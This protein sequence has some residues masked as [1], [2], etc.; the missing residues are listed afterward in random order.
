MFISDGILGSVCVTSFW[1][2]TCSFNFLFFAFS[3]FVYFSCFLIFS[4]RAPNIFFSGLLLSITSSGNSLSWPSTS[5]SMKSPSSNWTSCCPVG[6]FASLILSPLKG[7]LGVDGGPSWVGDRLMGL[8]GGDRQGSSVFPDIVPFLNGSLG[9]GSRP[10][11][12]AGLAGGLSKLSTHFTLVSLA[13]QLLGR[14]FFSAV[15]GVLHL[16]G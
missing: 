9:V 14:P 10:I 15:V 16:P 5:S 2:I 12:E 1:L 6:D 3:F 8:S 11:S 4:W 13:L 7:S